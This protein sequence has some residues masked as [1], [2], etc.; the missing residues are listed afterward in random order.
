MEAQTISI[1]KS[2]G[3]PL[4]GTISLQTVQVR[5]LETPKHILF[6]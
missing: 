6:V 2:A 5:P 4:D 1:L 3:D